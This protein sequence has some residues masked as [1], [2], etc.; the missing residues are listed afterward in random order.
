MDPVPI[1]RH[2]IVPQEWDSLAAA[3]QFQKLLLIK[4]LFIVPVLLFSLAYCLALPVPVGIAPQVMA[5]KVFGGTN[6]GYVFPAPQFFEVWFVAWR[7]LKAGGDSGH[8][9]KKGTLRDGVIRC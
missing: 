8:A 2:A 5:A 9:G 7:Y 1:D 6:L 3:R 4:K